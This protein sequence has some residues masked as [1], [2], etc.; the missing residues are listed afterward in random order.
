M[1]CGSGADDH[2]GGA[3]AGR[4]H[5]WLDCVEAAPRR[6]AGG[7]AQTPRRHEH[8]ALDRYRVE[9]GSRVRGCHGSDRAAGAAPSTSRFQAI[10]RDWN[11]PCT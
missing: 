8:A 2:D 5:P 9:R 4:R 6:G 11:A 10:S 3:T 7:A 1:E